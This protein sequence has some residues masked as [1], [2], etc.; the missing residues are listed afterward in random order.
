MYV[1]CSHRDTDH[2]YLEENV[3]F[4]YKNNDILEKVFILFFFY[5]ENN[6]NRND[7]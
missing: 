5:F 6:F 2:G 1:N 7:T 4:I 3:H